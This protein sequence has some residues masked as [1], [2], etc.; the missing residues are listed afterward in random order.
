VPIHKCAVVYW[1]WNAFFTEAKKKLW[2]DNTILSLYRS[3]QS[4]LLWRIS[5]AD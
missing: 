1:L 2:F 5:K 3:L 4:D